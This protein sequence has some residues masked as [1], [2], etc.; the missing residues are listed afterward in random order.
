MHNTAVVPVEQFNYSGLAVQ[1][2]STSA[3]RLKVSLTVSQKMNPQISDSLNHTKIVLVS[4]F[5]NIKKCK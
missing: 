1:L 3:Q 2:D 5:L 4:A